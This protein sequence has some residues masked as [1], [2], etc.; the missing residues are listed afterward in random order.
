M[1]FN[2]PIV[3]GTALRIP[4]IQSP[5]YSPGVSGWIIKING[6]AEFNN[7]VVRGEFLGT[8]FILNS[9]GLFFYSS[10][11]AA[12]NLVMSAASDQGTD[13]FGNSF[14]RGLMVYNPSA[15]SSVQIDAGAGANIVNF[16]PPD[17]TGVTWANGSVSVG[18]GSRLGTN[19][20]QL[21]LVSPYNTSPSASQSSLT[22]YGRPQTG[23]DPD[24]VTNEIFASTQRFTVTGDLVCPTMQSRTESV[25]S[26]GAVS[27][28]TAAVTFD[29][30]YPAGVTPSVSAN[31]ATGSGTFLRW[32][33]KAIS[34]T[35][36]GFT[37]ALNKGDAADPAATWTN[38]PVSWI[39]HGN[40]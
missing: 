36:T 26:S 23:T 24:G 18:T 2:N 19:T 15:G 22:L 14:G 17:V 21:A 11:P 28:F 32:Q 9:S 39:S 1:G 25:S 34:I 37:L 7:L 4:A 35:N 8:N 38:Q 31:I 10:T 33:V 29:T 5:N 12:G 27:S 16:D 30:A 20:P 40:V 13:S 6:D 3:G